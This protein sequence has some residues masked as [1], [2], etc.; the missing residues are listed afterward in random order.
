MWNVCRICNPGVIDDQ[1]DRVDSN[2]NKTKKLF[3]IEKDYFLELFMPHDS[4][5]Q[6]KVMDLTVEYN[7]FLYYPFVYPDPDR[8]PFNK[9][10]SKK[11][12]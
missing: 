2:K 9:K 7:R 11:E 3:G 12:R 6:N 1:S 5:F 4:N 10:N 8:F